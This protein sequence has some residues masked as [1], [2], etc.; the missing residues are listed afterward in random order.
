M[1]NLLLCLLLQVSLCGYMISQVLCIQCLDQNDPVSP[2]ATN[3]I[4]NGGFESTDCIPGWL[5]GSYCPNSD[6]YNC[7]LFDWVCTDGD[8]QTYTSVFDSTLSLIPEGHNAAYFGN[9]NAFTC[10]EFWND[11]SCLTFQECTVAALFPPGFPKSLEG[12]GEQKGVSLEQTV[13]GLTVGHTYILEFWAG[14]EPLEGLLS[15]NGIFAIDVGFGKSFLTCKPTDYENYQVGQIYLVE[16]TANSP[17]HKIKFTN[18]GHVCDL[19]TELVIDNVRLY[20]LEELNPNVTLCT[21][22]ANDLIADQLFEINPNP[23][24]HELQV[25][26]GLQQSAELV[27]YNVLGEQGMHAAILGN[28]A[29]NT[30]DIQRGI[31]FYQIRDHGKILQAGKLV[32]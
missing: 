25:S 22:S 3:R 9:G 4:Q 20:A 27:L 17:S 1:K 10:S 18:W 13:S 12:Y 23:F 30:R 31:Y 2:A 26:S 11:F 7:D 24:D 15:E 28:T 14:G 16:F 29:V 21:T 32:K 19:C 8:V 5:D 6:K